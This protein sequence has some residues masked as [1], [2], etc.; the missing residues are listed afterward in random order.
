MYFLVNWKFSQKLQVWFSNRR[1][2]WRKQIG[3]TQLPMGNPAAALSGYNPLTGTPTYMLNS[4]DPSAAAA[5]LHSALPG[6]ASTASSLPGLSSISANSA[7]NLSASLSTSYSQF[8]NRFNFP[9]QDQYSAV[10][11]KTEH[12]LTAVSSETCQLPHTC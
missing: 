1:A 2:R 7:A 4:G 11:W 9:N 10:S 5:A 12:S 6:L 8:P 3:A